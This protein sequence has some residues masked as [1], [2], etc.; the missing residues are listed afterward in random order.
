MTLT[1]SR[2]RGLAVIS[3]QGRVRGRVLDLI[4]APEGEE[5]AVRALLV[6]PSRLALL[7]A[8]FRPRPRATTIPA[9]HIAAIDARGI[10]LAAH[11][12]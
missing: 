8:R 9:S 5:M 11:H 7:A 12:G 4:A 1:Y 3:P 2:L 10:H 6:A